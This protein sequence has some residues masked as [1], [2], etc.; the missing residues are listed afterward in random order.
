MTAKG[1]EMPDPT[2]IRNDFPRT[3]AT[4]GAYDEARRAACARRAATHARAPVDWR[5]RRALMQEEEK[6]HLARRAVLLAYA[7]ELLPAILGGEWTMCR[8]GASPIWQPHKGRG[9]VD[10]A[11]SFTGPLLDHTHAFRR[12]GMRGPLNWRNGALTSE[13]YD[14]F[15]RK[16]GAIPASAEEHARL[17][18]AEH[19]LGTWLHPDLSAWFRGWTTLIIIASALRPEDAGGFGFIPLA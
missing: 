15:D 12:A 1:T 2:L 5:A 9:V 10:Y 17:L 19:G 11:Q 14:A 13:P 18:R 16:A 8:H 6:E 3:R 4:C 7:S